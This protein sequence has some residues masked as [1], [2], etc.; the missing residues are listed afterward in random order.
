MH[1][2]EAFTGPETVLFYRIPVPVAGTWSPDASLD[3]VEDES[4]RYTVA[5]PAERVSDLR[6]FLR[7]AGNTFDQRVIYL[8]VAG[9]AELLEVR[10]DDG[11]L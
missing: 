4:R 8:D 11:F 5:I 3:P 2:F 6:D 9:Y 7:K 1:T 10:P